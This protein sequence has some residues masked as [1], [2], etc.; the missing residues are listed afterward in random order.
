VAVALAF[1]GSEGHFLLVAAD[2][3]FAGHDQDVPKLFAQ[4]GL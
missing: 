4:L 2:R 1:P 3:G